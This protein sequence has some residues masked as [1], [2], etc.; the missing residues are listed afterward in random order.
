[1]SDDP[2][3][4]ILAA[5]PWR[6]LCALH[7]ESPRDAGPVL[8]AD[9]RLDGQARETLL[10]ELH[11]V[12]LPELAAD[13]FVELDRTT[14]T[15]RPG[16]RFELL[17]PL[18]DRPPAELRGLDAGPFTY[19]DDTEIVQYDPDGDI[20]QLASSLDTGHAEDTGLNERDDPA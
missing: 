3:E 13:G 15:V 5:Q 6:L 18:L 19:D 12:L 4:R 16:P 10:Y 2:P 9:E 14:E 8:R 20:E 7:E 17:G 1:M 11:H